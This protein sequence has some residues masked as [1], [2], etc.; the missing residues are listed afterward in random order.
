[1]RTNFKSLI[2]IICFSLPIWLHAQNVG[3][4]ITTPT[5]ARLQ[6]QGSVGSNVLVARTSAASSGLTMAVVGSNFPTFGFNTEISS[7]YKRINNGYASFFQYDALSGDNRYWSST[8]SAAAGTSFG[9]FQPLTLQG[10]G[11]V[12]INNYLGINA[13]GNID[14]GRVIIAHNSTIASP[15]LK[16]LETSN[17][18]Y[19]R[20]ELSNTATNRFWHIAGYNAVAGAASDRLNFYHSTAGDIMSITGDGRI[21]IG[22]LSPAT[23]YKLSI[24][25]K[26]ICTELKVQVA[27]AWPDYVFAKKYQLRSLPDLEA[28]IAENQHLP[29]IPSAEEVKNSGI[30]IGDMQNRLMEKVEE[31]T[32]Y[33]IEQNKKILAQNKRI[34][35][36]EKKN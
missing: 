7:G 15:T 29:N 4:G 20:L 9:Y 28:Y 24:N 18:D 2:F 21:G 8:D 3:I 1:M 34:Q 16:L 13:N 23:G 19:T 14:S 11:N 32:L 26:V 22:T 35:K 5:M 33:I 17:S 30:S 36:L 31:L 10:S 6:I 27:A 25:G 12:R